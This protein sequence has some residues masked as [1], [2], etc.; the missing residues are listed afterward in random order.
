M[1]DMHEVCPSSGPP[2]LH[3]SPLTVSTWLSH[4]VALPDLMWAMF[5]GHLPWACH[6]SPTGRHQYPCF[7]HDSFSKTGQTCPLFA[8]A[9]FLGQRPVVPMWCPE[10]FQVNFQIFTSPIFSLW[11]V[12]ATSRSHLKEQRHDTRNTRAPGQLCTTP[13]L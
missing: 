10:C 2:L 6:T 8:H 4:S 9:S 7:F 12:P 1:L 13:P 3:F 5:T 11:W